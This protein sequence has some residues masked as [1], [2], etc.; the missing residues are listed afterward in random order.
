MVE[1]LN[2]YNFSLLPL[3]RVILKTWINAPTKLESSWSFLLKYVG[4]ARA[5]EEPA[6]KTAKAVSA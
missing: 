5:Y 1:E 3:Q 6:K 2:I 4:C